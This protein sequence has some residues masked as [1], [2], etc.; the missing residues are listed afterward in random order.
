M[1]CKTFR[2]RYVIG[3][4]DID[5]LFHCG[6][7]FMTIDYVVS[8]PEDKFTCFRRQQLDRLRINAL[9]S[10]YFLRDITIYF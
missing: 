4:G 3:A 5:N 2:N 7:L 10:H 9:I 1:C 6:Q 8:F